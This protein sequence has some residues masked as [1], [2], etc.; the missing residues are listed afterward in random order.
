MTKEQFIEKARKIHGNKYD[1]SKV[2][3]KNNKTKVCIICP[4][5]GEF[6]MKPNTHLNEHGCPICGAEK[7]KKTLRD[8]LGF[9]TAEFIIKAKEV[10]GNKYD[11]SKV[12]Y[13]NTDTKVCIICPIHGEFWQTPDAHLRGQGCRKCG[14]ESNKTKQRNTTNDFIIKAQLIHGNKYDYSKAEYKNNK[15]KICIIC[16]EHGEFWQTPAD[17]L[18]GHGCNFCNESKLEKDI[19]LLLE[20][21]KIRF[22]HH[23]S[24]DDF[25][26]IGRKH[27]DFY[28]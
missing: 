28:L 10:H 6:W 22:K 16:K 12:E 24:K 26:W 18:N 3:Y 27:L 1:Y 20:E 13:V 14:L 9:T 7:R 5:H 4:I 11:Y 23:A 25:N 8:K 15:T 19:R 21:K 2:E 17:H